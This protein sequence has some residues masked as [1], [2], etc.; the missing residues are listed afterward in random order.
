MA[1][2]AFRRHI[3]IGRQI[4]C[5][6][7]GGDDAETGGAGPVDHF[8]GQRRL[9][10]VSERIDH[11]RLPR[12][13]GEQRPGQHVG[14]DIDHH[15]MLAGRYRRAGVADA[16]RGIA[17]RLHHHID[18]AARNRP[19]AVIGEG[20]GLDPRLVPADGAAGLA[21]AI[22]VEIDDQRH[23]Q[24]RCVRYLRQEHRA[25]LSGADQRHPNR[26]SG[27]GADVEEMGEV[28][29][30]NPMR[31]TVRNCCSAAYFR[32]GRAW[33]SE[34]RRRFRSP[35]PGHPRPGRRDTV[36]TWMPGTSPG[37]TLQGHAADY[38]AACLGARARRSS[39]SSSAVWIGVK[40]R[41]AIYSGRVGVRM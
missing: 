7:A 13:L 14:L 10:A 26:F 15:D 6:L 35:M 17:G 5:A 34:G 21:R 3:V 11:A 28:H 33:P 27:G 37:M 29:G 2:D 18:R 41:C 39:A 40:S 36:A 12:L 22:A 9:I 30:R 8:G 31:K 1:P 23:L 19:Q 16:D 4:F 20:G 25:E 32:H 24:S 38:S